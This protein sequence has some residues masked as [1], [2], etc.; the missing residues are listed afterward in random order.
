MR[1]PRA[2][3][4]LHRGFNYSRGACMGQTYTLAY[5]ERSMIGRLHHFV[6]ERQLYYYISAT[7]NGA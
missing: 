6:V 7:R 3:L 2:Y 5:N 4:A 1:N